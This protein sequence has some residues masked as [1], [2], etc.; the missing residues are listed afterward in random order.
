MDTL[1]DEVLSN[2]PSIS[3]PVDWT[4]FSAS[5]ERLLLAAGGLPIGVSLVFGVGVAI[6]MTRLLRSETPPK[7]DH[8]AAEGSSAGVNRVGRFGETCAMGDR[9]T[10]EH[11]DLELDNDTFDKIQ[12]RFNLV[13]Q[14]QDATAH[15]DAG[16]ESPVE[17]HGHTPTGQTI[18]DPEEDTVGEQE[19]QMIIDDDHE[20]SEEAEYINNE[21]GGSSYPEEVTITCNFRSR[22]RASRIGYYKRRHDSH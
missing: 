5:P 1:M 17:C 12:E 14:R 7:A 21:E 11:R 10:G 18:E 9:S 3:W 13:L 2:F 15:T 19:E 20:E 8:A 4:H 16:E 6:V 22:V